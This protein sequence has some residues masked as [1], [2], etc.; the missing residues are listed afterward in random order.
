VQIELDNIAMETV[1]ALF[2]GFMVFV[3]G[4]IIG[5]FLNVVIHRLPRD[6]SIVLPPSHCPEC[7]YQIKPYDNIPVVSYLLLRGRCRS[8]RTGISPIYP[9]VELLVG[10]LYLSFFLLHRLTPEFIVDV[11]FVS[12]TVPLVFIDFEHMLLPN[13]ITYPGLIVGF[14]LRLLV[15]IPYL[16]HLRAAPGF[17]TW[18]AWTVSLIASALGA[19]AGGGVL[20]LI[21]EVYYRTMRRE[22]MGPGDV[23]MML[24][25]GAFLGW[26]L[27]IVTIFFAAFGGSIIGLLLIVLRG[28]SMKTAIPFG[29]FLGPSAILSLA[30]GEKVVAW[31]L[32]MLH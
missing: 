19:L 18:P 15:P 22:G 11:I 1:P 31:Y 17:Q 8:C 2:L 23:K 21:R 6:E 16:D 14:I 10:C 4:L 3:F 27:T 32:G 29:V 25:V 20:W 12:L 13:A 7:G 5:S 28:G 24:M 9:I 26:E 30:V